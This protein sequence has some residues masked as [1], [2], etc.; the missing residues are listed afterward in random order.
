MT[1]WL[2][3]PAND[4]ATSLRHHSSLACATPG[5]LTSSTMSS[6]SRQNA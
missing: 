2:G 4:C 5:S 1:G 6:I 3:W